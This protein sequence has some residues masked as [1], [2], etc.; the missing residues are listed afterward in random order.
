MEISTEIIGS[1]PGVIAAGMAA[2]TL[3]VVAV[4]VIVSGFKAL[5]KLIG[6]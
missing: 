6:R 1:M 2:S 5:L 3:V 4:S